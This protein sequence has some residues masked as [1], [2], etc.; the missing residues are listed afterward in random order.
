M[1]IKK[2]SLNQNRIS[3]IHAETGQ[4]DYFRFLN[5]GFGSLR[6]VHYQLSLAKRLGF[7][8]NE[9]SSLIETKVL[10]AEKVLNSLIGMTPSDCAV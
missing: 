3:T 8:F 6:E 2:C 5:M 4:E 1:K 10:Y 9:D 7:F